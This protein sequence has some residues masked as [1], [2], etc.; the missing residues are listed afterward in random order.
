MFVCIGVVGGGG[1]DR[2]RET[3]TE[4]EREGH[5]QSKWNETINKKEKF[6]TKK[7]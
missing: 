3:E 5:S 2:E 1:R 7:K 6:Q 4:R